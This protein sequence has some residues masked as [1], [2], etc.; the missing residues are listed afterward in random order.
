MSVEIEPGV[1]TV[2]VGR[3]GCGKSTLLS[4]ALDVLPRGL[5]RVSGDVTLSGQSL[6][7]S[8]QA[9]RGARGR[10]I[11]LCFQ[12]P[13]AALNPSLSLGRHFQDVL[14]PGHRDWRER[15]LSLLREVDVE[16]GAKR[17]GQYAHQ[18]SGGERQRVVIALTIAND[19]TYLLADEPVSA[20]DP[21]TAE[22]ILSLLQ[23]LQRS[24]GLGLLVVT[25]DWRVVQRYADRVL[26]M[27]EGRIVERGSAAAILREP[28][29]SETR[30]LLSA[31]G[32]WEARS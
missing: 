13:Q 1:T 24:R 7:V 20:L 8:G 9:M 19:P 18:L 23:R 29:H 27:A 12:E 28:S 3:S 4:A 32:L 25:H 10:E 2:L 6:L 21:A 31:A 11:A 15:A 16:N 26:V 14:Q 22:I 30:A 5:H 17:L